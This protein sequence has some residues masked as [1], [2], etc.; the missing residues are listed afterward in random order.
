MELGT[1][2]GKIKW[3]THK[4]KFQGRVYVF[5]MQIKYG[6]IPTMEEKDIFST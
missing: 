1:E 6:M 3:S 4:T 5:E 2:I